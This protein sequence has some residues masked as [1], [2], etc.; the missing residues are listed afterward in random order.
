M[1]QSIVPFSNLHHIEPLLINTGVC[2]SGLSC[3]PVIRNKFRPRNTYKITLWNKK[4]KCCQA[5][6]MMH[7]KIQQMQTN[8]W[9]AS[10]HRLKGSCPPEEMNGFLHSPAKKPDISGSDLIMG[11]PTVKTVWGPQLA[12]KLNMLSI[13]TQWNVHVDLEN[14]PFH[15]CKCIWIFTVP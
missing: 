15:N 4:A 13:Q 12:Y 6:V 9:Q 10:W 5:K 8:P 1:M 3:F 14:I 11:F 2:D 7:V